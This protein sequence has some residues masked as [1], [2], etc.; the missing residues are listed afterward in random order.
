MLFFNIVRLIMEFTLW[1]FSSTW[2]NF[3]KTRF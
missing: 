2:V 3:W 1:I